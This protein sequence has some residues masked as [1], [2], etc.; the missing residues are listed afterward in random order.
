MTLIMVLLIGTQSF[1]FLLKWQK[2][3]LYSHNI[4]NPIDI[5]KDSDGSASLWDHDVDDIYRAPIPGLS[6]AVSMDPDT[7][8]QLY[9]LDS[10]GILRIRRRTNSS[11]QK[12]TKWTSP[13]IIPTDPKPKKSSPLAAIAFQFQ[14]GV[15]ELR[16]YYLDESNR[17]VEFATSFSLS[18]SPSWYLG[19][20]FSTTSTGGLTAVWLGSEGIRL[21]CI[22]EDNSVA[23]HVWYAG[24][25]RDPTSLNLPALSGS[26]LAIQT[27]SPENQGLLGIFLLYVNADKDLTEGVYDP[28]KDPNNFLP[29]RII[30]SDFTGIGGGIS[31]A[32]AIDYNEYKWRAYYLAKNTG[33]V[34]QWAPP[35]ADYSHYWQLIPDS[36][37]PDVFGGA[38]ATV[39]W[40]NNIRVFYVSAG[41][42]VE[43]ALL[44]TSDRDGSWTSMG[45]IA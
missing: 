2:S 33:L 7:N 42:I 17:I 13:Q 5:T 6:I 44:Y 16:V 11:D 34:E 8:I 20:Y 24:S 36:P 22:D 43:E 26:P 18:S 15:T 21:Y 1:R 19:K 28:S 14:T 41:S 37:V 29:G 40:K 30:D 25:W 38:V 9:D 31:S 4:S 10:S 32:I 39:V 27:F 3:C 45:K 23:Q 35:F 12:N